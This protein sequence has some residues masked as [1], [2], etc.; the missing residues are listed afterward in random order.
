MP[1]QGM[2]NS[3]Q[4]NPLQLALTIRNIRREEEA[5]EQKNMMARV[6]A[7]QDAETFK[8]TQEKLQQEALAKRLDNASKLNGLA[9]GIAEA[10]RNAANQFDASDLS[11]PGGGADSDAFTGI[12]AQADPAGV[13]R[14]I[15]AQSVLQDRVGLAAGARQQLSGG[16]RAAN[17]ASVLGASDVVSNEERRERALANK[18][19]RRRKELD[20]EFNE[21]SAEAAEAR[22]IGNEY[23][24][25]GSQLDTIREKTKIELKPFIAAEQQRRNVERMNFD[26]PLDVLEAM[27]MY[28]K[29]NDDGAVVREA[30]I[31]L[32]TAM[33]ASTLEEAWARAKGVFDAEGSLPPDL[34][35][36]IK[37]ALTRQHEIMDELAVDRFKDA[38]AFAE[39]QGWDQR[40]K[41]RG[42][43][44]SSAV[45]RAEARIKAR[46][47]AT[48]IG[49]RAMSENDMPAVNKKARELFGL[50]KGQEATPEQ[51]A[52]AWNVL[53]VGG[54]S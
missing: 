7:A 37:N 4:V 54:G 39:T 5:A 28:I 13:D 1:F 29:N 10:R 19:E 44:R 45:K 14:G 11:I 50:K 6:K 26:D 20:F 42:L 43:P 53:R 46:E 31:V 40:Q 36:K 48:P 12:I 49:S 32:T 33:G 2:P 24:F 21:M 16:D 23:R 3:G 18:D 25:S 9:P 17:V 34:G 47:K 51:S 22:A 52:A 15:N 8:L 38:E 41:V 27:Q 35:K 30:D